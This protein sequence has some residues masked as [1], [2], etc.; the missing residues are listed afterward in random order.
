MPRPIDDLK[1]AFGDIIERT[2]AGLSEL[3]GTKIYISEWAASDGYL[4]DVNLRPDKKHPAL[5]LSATYVDKAGNEFS[6]MRVVEYNPQTGALKTMHNELLEVPPV[7]QGHHAADVVNRHMAGEFRK[8]GGR[9]IEMH[10]NLNAGGYAWLRKGVFPASKSELD[11]IVSVSNIPESSKQKWLSWDYETAKRKM[12]DKQSAQEFKPAFVGS[13]WRGGVDIKSA[14]AFNVFTGSRISDDKTVNE[15]W[16]SEVIARSVRYEQFAESLSDR[17]AEMLDSV[18]DRI[19]SKLSKSLE[20]PTRA[21]ARMID[22]ADAIAALRA[23]RWT[24]VDKLVTETAIKLSRAEAAATQD[25]LAARLPVRV[26]T[27]L[28]SARTLTSVVTTR[29]FHGRLLSG[30]LDRLRDNDAARVRNAVQTGIVAG[31]S[32][33][34]IARDITDGITAKRTDAEIRSVVRTAVS[35]ISNA[36]REQFFSENKELFAEELFVAT[37]DSRTSPI[38]RALDGQ[39]FAIGEGQ[40]PPLHFNCR[41]I[42]VAVFSEALGERPSNPATERQLLAEFNRE[43]GLDATSRDKLPHGMKGKFDKFATK[44]KREIIGQIPAKTNY[45]KWLREQ[46]DEF[47]NEVL[48]I[49]R[50]KLFRDGD[51]ELKDFVRPDGKQI[52]LADLYKEYESTFKRLGIE[53]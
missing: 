31:Q 17:V 39:R 36:S 41:S 2:R 4:L 21:Q 18:S 13:S 42:R 28:P 8:L 33:G 52:S 19:I 3:L 5:T 37:L 53:L 49:K 23:E 27:L 22:V 12:L 32:A 43:N 29:P 20:N 46:S 10:A 35:H 9:H 38:C 30:W 26:D 6:V 34:Q 14:N 7:Y 48:G 16:Q 47:Q 25:W 45:E 24:N 11:R 50:A 15:Q 44:R 40:R 1:A 51:L